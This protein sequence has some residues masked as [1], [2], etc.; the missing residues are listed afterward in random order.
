MYIFGSNELAQR[1]WDTPNLHFAG[2]TPNEMLEIDEKAV[3]KYIDK[4]FV[5]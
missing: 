4:L 1:W 3:H 2:A 5:V